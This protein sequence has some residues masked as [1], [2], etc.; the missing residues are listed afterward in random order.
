MR[1]RS[2]RL[3]VRLVK[4]SKSNLKVILA[5]DSKYTG[6]SAEAVK[7]DLRRTTDEVV[8]PRPIRLAIGAEIGRG[9]TTEGSLTV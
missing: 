4:N 5:S 8:R 7:D 3:T 1:N 2:F 9:E 6:R